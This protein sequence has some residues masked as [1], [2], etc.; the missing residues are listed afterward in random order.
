MSN[1]V[2]VETNEEPDQEL[3]YEPPIVT[4]PPKCAY[5]GEFM[6]K[7]PGVWG[8]FFRQGYA[9]SQMIFSHRYNTWEHY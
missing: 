2:L 1:F 5:C 9:C 3:F 6:R 7:E 4:N 8:M